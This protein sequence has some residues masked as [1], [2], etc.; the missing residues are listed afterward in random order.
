[1]ED[2]VLY[3]EGPDDSA[4][5]QAID[6]GEEWHC[7]L[8]GAVIG[9]GHRCKASDVS[10][11][12]GEQLADL[13]MSLDKLRQRVHRPEG[14]F[15]SRADKPD[16]VTVAASKKLAASRK[17]VK[18][19]RVE[20]DEFRMEIFRVCAERDHHRIESARAAAESSS[21]WEARWREAAGRLSTLHAFVGPEIAGLDDV[22]LAEVAKAKAAQG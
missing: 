15:I 8:C 5:E 4:P 12:L 21:V 17:L 13:A 10:D 19:L 18:R 6:D 3:H 16:P 1:M 11:H 20:R 14:H 22:A 2:Q 7:N 9:D